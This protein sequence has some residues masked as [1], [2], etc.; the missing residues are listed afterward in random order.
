MNSW[1]AKVFKVTHR[2]LVAL[3]ACYVYADDAVVSAKPLATVPYEIRRGQ[4]VL[5]ATVNGTN[6]LWM[7]LDTG[8]GITMLKPKVIESLGLQK[9]GS[10]TIE[11]IAGEERAATYQSPAFDF[12]GAVYTTRRVAALDSEDNR[13]TRDGI[14]SSSFFRRFV[15]ELE[16]KEKRASLWA[17]TNYTYQGKGEILKLSFRS[18][19]PIIEAAMT[20]PKGEK[21]MAKL[22]LDSGCSGALCLG[23]DFVEQHGLTGAAPGETSRRQGIGGGART[24]TGSVKRLHLGALSRDNVEADFFLDGS[25]ADEGHA[26]HL[27]F[28]VLRHYKVIFD[29]ARNRLILEP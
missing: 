20:T 28:G 29:Y 8:F 14:L 19:T 7:M 5:P 22:E 9:A 2:T 17:P 1:L 18:T 11:G 3:L 4:A 13:R 6:K 23:K 26:G 15:I 12:G 24:Q 27:G 16:P 10:V 21:V 25:P